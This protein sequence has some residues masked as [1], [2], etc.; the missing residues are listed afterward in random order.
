MDTWFSSLT[1]GIFYGHLEYFVAI[2]EHF[3]PFWYVVPRIIWQ[4]CSGKE[5]NI[6]SFF[7]SA[8]FRNLCTAEGNVY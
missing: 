6:F 8:T 5:N 4:P 1:F 7:A 2:L 3:P